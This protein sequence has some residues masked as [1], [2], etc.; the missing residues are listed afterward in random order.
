MW[1]HEAL[2][3]RSSLK[4][5]LIENK[6]ITSSEYITQISNALNSIFMILNENRQIIFA[7]KHLLSFLS[8]TD[9][10]LL[11]KRP[12]EILYCK[13]ATKLPTGC[14]THEY[15]QECGALNTI[16]SALDGKTV[17]NECRISSIIDGQN[18]SFD[19]LVKGQPFH[20]ENRQYVLFSIIDISD[21]K[22]KKILEK[23]FFHDILNTA[24]GVIGFSRM[25]KDNLKDGDLE[26]YEMAEVLYDISD[27]LI[28]EIKS[29]QLLLAAENNNLKLDITEFQTIEFLKK[30]INLIEKNDAV[31]NRN[32]NLSVPKDITI[33][34]DRVLLQ[35]IIINMI[36]N[37]AEAVSKEETV[38]V[39]AEEN[40]TNII[41]S[42]HNKSYINKS[43]QAQIFQRSFSTKG[44]NRG[45]GTY[46]IKL[47]GENYLKGKVWFESTEENGTTFYLEIPTTI[48][49]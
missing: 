8:I 24:G 3:K 35:K 5:V 33:K 27:N 25:L 19:L 28:K 39:K 15:C 30:T 11:G 14:G 34:T 22:R 32:I 36:K 29:Q 9:E 45:I 21:K 13:N 16:L 49:N 44:V 12:G 2:I 7:N 4:E 46:S 48:N 17:E 31:K 38:T 18:V 23:T 42:I 6:N 26:N 43:T 20:Y 40:E 10:N 1:T 41:F 37:A 47:F